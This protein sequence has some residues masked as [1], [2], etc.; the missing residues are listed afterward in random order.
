MLKLVG[1][2]LQLLEIGV[3]NILP[4]IGILLILV[5]ENERVLPAVEPESPIPI[6]TLSFVQLKVV[7]ATVEPLKG[8]LI[9]V[10]EHTTRSATGLILGVGFTTKLKFLV[11]PEQPLLKGVTVNN[12]AIGTLKI[13]VT[14]KLAIV[15]DP[16]VLPI[17]ILI[18]LFVQL[19][20]VPLTIEPVNVIALLII[21]E[22]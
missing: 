9:S 19:Y 11:A 6:A 16:N 18:L 15:P 4:V 22:Q 21:P 8:K 10:P 5:A 13:L 12:E 20:C 1:I 3:T 17:P 7:L 2:P 14:V